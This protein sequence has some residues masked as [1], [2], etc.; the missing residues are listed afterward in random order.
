[1]INRYSHKGVTWIDIDH[2]SEKD[3]ET[4]IKE[5][6]IDP[7]LANEILIPTNRPRVELNSDY[8]YLVLHFPAFK[9]SHKEKTE[10]EVDFIIGKDFL[11]TARY[12][13]VDAIH[14]FG[15]KLEVSNIL[16]KKNIEYPAGYLFY[17]I[18]KEIYHSIFDELAFIE[19]WIKDVEN[20]IFKGNER[21][22]VFALSNIS[23][24]LIDFKKTTDM[25]EEILTTLEI[26]GKRLFGDHFPHY[27]R[28]A[29]EEYRKI[30]GTI[31]ADMEV[32]VELRETNNSLLETKQNEITKIL[33]I[34]AFIAVPL[35]LIASI[36]QIDTVSRPIIG[37]PHDFWILIGVILLIGATMFSFFKF[38][39]W[40]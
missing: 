21:E 6:D 14:K 28:T 35:S 19:S 17:I 12:D 29:L 15:K 13:T 9:H 1:M 4:I 26:A 22:M 20:K 11:I 30:Q 25:H 36:F 32:I 7:L 5:F 34:L 31:K 38:K 10:Q 33:T 3:K 2:P 18:L 39:G 16:D 37:Q 23:R 40:L 27:T 24:T 8:I